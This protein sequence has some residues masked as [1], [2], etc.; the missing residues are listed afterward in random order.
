VYLVR[1]YLVDLAVGSADYN[2]YTWG[3][4]SKF[5]PATV[6]NDRSHLTPAGNAFV[7]LR[8]WLRGA[9]L[10]AVDIDSKGTWS[11]SL[12]LRDMTSAIMVWN[13]TTSVQFPIPFPATT[14]HD[15]FGHSTVLTSST[16]TVSSSPILVTSSHWLGQKSHLRQSR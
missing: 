9:S 1:R 15:I 12:T 16:L 4:S 2:W 8:D 10:V 3:A 6:S 13:P 14:V 11:F 5:C 7:L